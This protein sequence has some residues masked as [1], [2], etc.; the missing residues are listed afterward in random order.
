MDDSERRIRQARP[1]DLD[2][3]APLSDR[4]RAD[5]A[6]IMAGPPIEKP[7][8]RPTR[9]PVRIAW[10]AVA[11]AA[12]AVIAMVVSFSVLSAPRAVALT[13]PPL[14]FTATGQTAG[15]VL[16]GAERALAASAS[17]QE[18]ERGGSWTGWY[19]QLEMDADTIKTA[20]ISPQV[21][22]LRW[23]PDQSGRTT[24]IAGTPYWADG[25]ED[26]VPAADGPPAGTVISD[27][28][29]PAG[30]LG[31]PTADPPGTTDADMSAWLTT[32]G[33]PAQ[34][35]AADLIDGI[36]MT[37]SYWTL[38]NQQHAILLRLLLTRDDVHV[39]GTGTDRAGRPVIGVSAD[40]SRFPGSRRLLLISTDTGR[41]IAEEVLRTTP[42]G[43]LPAG[44]VM[45]YTLWGVPAA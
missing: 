1:D 25:S 14:T 13:P 3:H 24:V 43:P 35:D 22:A 21:T 2:R 36:D 19:T 42:D 27:M 7:M 31:L 30:G 34:R 8:P 15:E 28:T 32:M 18:P 37:M 16:A 20:A 6:R 38:T 11:V 44:S 9:R 26:P 33:R 29:F 39:A 10:A 40:S 5:L 45:S 41:I 4:A 17:P 12:V 23:E